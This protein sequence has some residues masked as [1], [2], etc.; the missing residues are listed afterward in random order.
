MSELRDYE[1]FATLID[2]YIKDSAFGRASD[3][4]RYLALNEYGGVYSD[5]DVSLN[6]YPVDL[7][8][9]YDFFGPDGDGF[10]L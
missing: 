5:T 6:Y 1:R 2:R 9:L 10:Q 4:V 7:H 3:L 8:Y